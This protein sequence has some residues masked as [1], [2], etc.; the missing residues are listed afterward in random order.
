MDYSRTSAPELIAAISLTMHF[1]IASRALA[2]MHIQSM[3]IS[4]SASLLGITFMSL[5]HGI[6]EGCKNGQGLLGFLQ[7]YCCE[8]L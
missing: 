3:L 4:Q 2:M 8:N 7:K 5:I 1:M 6:L